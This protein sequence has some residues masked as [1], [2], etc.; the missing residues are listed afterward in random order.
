[1][2]WFTEGLRDPDSIASATQEYKETSDALSGFLPGVLVLEAGA[3]MSG[4]DAFNQYLEWCEA[5]NL[6]SRERWTR[7]TFYSAMEERK[8]QKVRSAKGVALVGVRIAGESKP[9]SAGP[10]IFGSDDA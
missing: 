4:A 6:P 8:V 5:E 9:V 2:L 1:M 7:Q 10:G 3:R